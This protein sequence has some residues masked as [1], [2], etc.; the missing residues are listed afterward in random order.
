MCP[1]V[2]LGVMHWSPASGAESE[3]WYQWPNPLVVGVCLKVCSDCSLV[4]R[5][6]TW[7]QSTDY[8]TR[9][10]VCLSTALQ[11]FS[12][13]RPPLFPTSRY[14][15]VFV[16]YFRKY[17]NP[18]HSTSVVQKYSCN[19][20]QWGHML[21]SDKF[22]L[23]T[24]EYAKFWFPKQNPK[25]CINQ[26]CLVSWALPDTWQ[27]LYQ[28]QS[29]DNWMRISKANGQQWSSD[30]CWM[31]SSGQRSYTWLSCCMQTWNA[32]RDNQTLLHF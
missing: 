17:S 19:Y 7:L 5:S 13:K 9:W 23:S 32:W 6:T 3:S 10:R 14:T 1:E 8:S 28:L 16:Q 15:A 31:S 27:C 24:H 26:V 4:H 21:C 29:A 22:T 25:Q 2:P 18:V 30:S 20:S 11:Q 12:E